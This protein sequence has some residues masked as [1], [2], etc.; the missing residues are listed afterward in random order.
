MNIPRE[1]IDLVLAKIDIVD[2]INT[3]IPLRKKSGSNY[4]ARCPFH[5]EKSASF[6][7]SQPKQFYHCF[8]CG[9]HG[10]AIDFMMQ[11]ERLSFPEAIE[12][13]ARQT[14]MEIPHT[15][16]AIKK[17][18]SLPA[19][20]SLMTEAADYYY[21]HMRQSQH[22]INYLKKRG[23]SGKIAK[24]F[25]LG[26]APQGWGHV[27]DHFGK[28]EADK[29]KLLDVGLV[30]KKDEGGYYDRFRDR[31]LFPIED[32]RGRI[33]GFGGRII[34]QGEPKYLNSPE[35]PTFQK[36]HV[37][38]GL[39]QALKENHKLDKVLVVE[40]YMDVVALFQHDIT[41]AV[42]TLGTATTSYHLQRL[43]R[44]TSDIVFCFD[45][46]EAGRTAAWRALQVLFPLMQDG[47]QIRFLFLPDGEDPDSLVRKEGKP[48][49]ENRLASSLSLSAF[50]FQ[51][52]SRQSDLSTIE[53]RARFTAQALHYIKQMPSEILPEILLEELAKRARID[54]TELK[55]QV[56]KAGPASPNVIAFPEPQPDFVKPK[57]KPAMQTALGLLVQNPDLA[58]LVT[59]PLPESHLLGHAFLIRLL[60]IIQQN[61]GINTAG[62]IEYWRGQKEDRFIANL[63]CWE[64]S[65]PET[66]LASE[67]LG[68]LR[69]LNLLGIDEEINRLLAKASQ[70]ALTEEEKLEL[71][72]WIVQKKQ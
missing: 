15:T 42:A 13:L 31:I 48:A 35:T 52:L 69:Q 4:F 27:L 9:A 45:G 28:T 67:F 63:A 6:S 24:Q 20:F 55:Q 3:H 49:F 8:G 68:T 39:S 72:N 1:F 25:K 36:G 66:G 60:E 5:N 34:D 51:T 22:A 58:K 47:L 11:H 53:G 59:E 54:V 33:I 14:G 2:L 26:Y 23:I 16:T 17:N 44:Y 70:E 57:L 64:H 29:K 30:I 41:Y 71:S 61:P 10:N 18:D 65:I 40:G 43:A 46:D 19:L 7:V 37:L 12:A 62:I 21:E 38:Y 50:F 32:Y 56:K